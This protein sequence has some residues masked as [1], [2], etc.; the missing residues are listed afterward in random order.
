MAINALTPAMTQNPGN[1]YLFTRQVVNDFSVALLTSRDRLT[2]NRRQW[3]QAEQD[4][5]GQHQTAQDQL[6]NRRAAAN[7]QLSN[8]KRNLEASQEARR[9]AAARED[10]AA[11]NAIRAEYDRKLQE[12]QAMVTQAAALRDSKDRQ[13]KDKLEICLEAERA[14]R[15]ICEPD[16]YD[17]TV[18]GVK[19]ANMQKFETTPFV[20][21][22]NEIRRK[23]EGLLT[24]IFCAGQ[25]KELCRQMHAEIGGARKVVKRL[26]KEHQAEFEAVERD[27]A[28]RSAAAQTAYDAAIARQRQAYQA[29]TDALA[30]QASRENAAH[31]QKVSNTAARFNSEKA[32]LDADQA[33]ERR[34]FAADRQQKQEEFRKQVYHKLVNLDWPPALLKQY[35]DGV[36]ARRVTCAGYQQ[37]AQ[38]PSHVFMGLL[39]TD[40]RDLM[41][42]EEGQRVSQVFHK[43][44]PF[45]VRD[46]LLTVPL[47]LSMQSGFRFWISHDRSQ[48]T[49]AAAALN[50]LCANIL[51]SCPPGQV[52]F[53]PAALSDV[54][55]FAPL[56]AFESDAVRGEHPRQLMP[57]GVL[58]SAADVEELLKKTVNYI[59][60][61]AANLYGCA[62]L[63]EYNAKNPMARKPITV[64]ALLGFPQ[65]VTETA[66][67]Y[68]NTILRS[69]PKCGVYTIIAASDEQMA[70]L[71]PETQKLAQNIS[72][73]MDQFRLTE[74]GL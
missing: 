27:G 64:L 10:E 41:G 33:E 61:L 24:N 50:G 37:P 1:E 48:E 14:A 34:K 71:R 65:N 35:F 45:I 7:N 12:V 70:S 47:S 11:R 22:R 72:N 31:A 32:R 8:E 16:V 68:L 15:N 40:A 55:A 5:R 18:K 74:N 53:Y 56:A 44:Y 29:K 3:E 21:M 67:N 28:R 63:Q 2:Q 20:E 17:K 42:D 57:E 9:Q 13:Q 46:S 73:E 58:H 38:M 43:N 54:A 60:D 66:M 52:R 51:L 49:R 39:Q 30:Q 62:S 25:I 59:T 19:A 69:G 26:E 4:L 36:M 6:A 23:K